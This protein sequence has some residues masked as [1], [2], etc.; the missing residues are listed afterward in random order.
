[1]RPFLMKRETILSYRIVVSVDL[2]GWETNVE[3]HP[4]LIKMLIK[5]DWSAQT[6]LDGC[7]HITQNYCDQHGGA[8]Y[9][10]EEALL[11]ALAYSEPTD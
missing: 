8:Q 10:V 11:I 4:A 7:D 2:Q 6:V 9:A 3:L 5:C 1:M